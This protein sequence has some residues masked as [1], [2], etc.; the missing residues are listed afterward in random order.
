MFHDSLRCISLSGWN[1]AAG[2]A[3][4]QI[5]DFIYLYLFSFF[6]GFG[7]YPSLYDKVVLSSWDLRAYHPYLQA[8]VPS[9]NPQSLLTSMLL[10]MVWEYA[11]E[12][13]IL[14]ALCCVPVADRAERSM[15]TV[16]LN[17]AARMFD[18]D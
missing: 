15:L 18:V 5:T 10:V 17:Y 3:V 4:Q 7:I 16:V 2:I 1:K 9:V 12:V 11:R 6:Q 13:T 8:G 14:E